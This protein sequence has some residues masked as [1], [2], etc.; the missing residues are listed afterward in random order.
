[1][2]VFR[3][4]VLLGCPAPLINSLSQCIGDGTLYPPQASAFGKDDM[5]GAMFN[6]K[7]W[8][9]GGLSGRLYSYFKELVTL[10]GH[11]AYS[12]LTLPGLMSSYSTLFAPKH[13][14]QIQQAFGWDLDLPFILMNRSRT[15]FTP[16]VLEQ[17]RKC[18]ATVSLS[19][20]AIKEFGWRVQ[21]SIS[22]ATLSS[23]VP[24]SINTITWDDISSDC[25]CLFFFLLLNS[26]ICPNMP[27]ACV[28][29]HPWS[30]PISRFLPLH[31]PSLR[32][33]QKLEEGG[34]KPAR[35]GNRIRGRINWDIK[36]DFVPGTSFR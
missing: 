34:C 9:K 8:L 18:L 16:K 33:P 27:I 12:N 24:V 10:S 11:T 28:S 6:W 31:Q 25:R 29:S 21:L 22:P 4:P 3:S 23:R 35:A 26:L 20:A 1:M 32:L 7:E 19:Q 15:G 5:E 36:S 14:I 2:R 13:L 17:R 30:R